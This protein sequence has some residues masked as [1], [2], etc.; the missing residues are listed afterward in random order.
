[1]VFATLIIALVF[2]PLMF[3][4]GIEGRFFRPLGIAFVV[5]ILASLLVALTVTPAM[6]RLFLRTRTAERGAGESPVVR[7]LKRFY[8]PVLDR[9]LRFR[10]IVLGAALATTLG[11]IWIGSTFGSSFLPEF[12]EGTFTVGLYGPPGTSLDASDRL[13]SAVERRLLAIDGSAA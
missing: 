11:A 3:L 1:M 5:S 4:E 6:C 8:A 9:A 2:L 12:N 13:A 7:T 10:S